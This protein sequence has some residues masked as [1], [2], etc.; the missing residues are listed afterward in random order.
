ME[1]SS[2]PANTLISAQVPAHYTSSRI[3]LYLP[4]HFT[5]Y[6]RNF[7]QKL[8]NNQF[9]KLNGKPVTK[10]ST[11]V[12]PGDILDVQFPPVRQIKPQREVVEPLNV[13]I[14]YEH[15]HFLIINKPAGLIVHPPHHLSTTVTL[16]DWLVTNF[17][18][19]ST[20]GSSD[21]PGIIHRLD[22]DT[23]GLMIITRTEYAHMVFGALFKDR[24]ISKTY[25][26]IVDGHPLAQGSI[27]FCIDRHPTDRNKMTH[28]L[29]RGR[30]ALTHYTV[31]EYLRDSALIEA[32]PITGRT[33][34]IRVHCAGI[35]H[36]LIGDSLYGEKSALI[37]RQALHAHKLSFTF[38]GKDYE[39]TAD[40]PEDMVNLLT[41]LKT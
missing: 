37:G 3:D 4:Q 6:S 26:A 35:G 38:D 22:K 9:I 17:N 13:K 23:S 1:A 41:T 7:F 34:Q 20:V 16:V 28:T 40:M 5:K 18:E 24:T 27:D 10:Y 8:I 25:L 19:V 12:K 21:R 32:K 14:I 29:F 11:I 15:E 36:S 31:H 33:H 30:Q 2:I 39:F